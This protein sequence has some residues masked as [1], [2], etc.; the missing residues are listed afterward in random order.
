MM[1][2]LLK[3]KKKKLENRLG[4]VKAILEKRK[5]NMVEKRKKKHVRFKTE[6]NKVEKRRKIEEGMVL[7]F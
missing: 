4:G 5:K 1:M 2:V 6:K 3:T 7:R